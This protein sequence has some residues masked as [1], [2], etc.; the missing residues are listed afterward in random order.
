[1]KVGYLVETPVEHRLTGGSRSFLDLLEQLVP[2]GVEPFVAVHEPWAL[3]EELEKRGIPFI[4]T[5][6]YRPFVGT[7]EKARFYRI[8][9][10]VK[11]LINAVSRRRVRSF[12]RKSG[13]EL[14]HVN[15][16][17][18][19][20]VGAQ[21]ARDLKLPYVYHI[22]EYLSSDFGVEFYNKKQADRL[23]GG[24]S[25]VVA[26]SSSI[27][28]FVRKKYP[29]ARVER[30][31]NGLNAEKVGCP[32]TVRFREE[33]VKIVI[34]GRVADAKN[35]REA[36]LATEL[37]V[38]EFHENVLLYVVGY[39]GKDPYELELAQYVKEKGLSEAVRFVPFSDDPGS[40]THTCDIGL[41]CSVREAFGRVTIENM[42]ASLLVIGSN[43]GGTPE[44]IRDG[45]DG[46]LYELGNPREL[47][48]KIRWAIHHPDEANALLSAGKKKAEETF[49]IQH[50]AQQVF[51]LYQRL[52]E[53]KRI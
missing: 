32:D 16:Q 44:L 10:L 6:M 29:A 22:R 34:V 40:I 45:E 1:M 27:E 48:E 53:G 7:E 9:Y 8:K 52:S 3:T 49:S 46:F 42:M 15:S 50:T 36:I 41:T 38:K 12:F 11:T 26:I 14:I 43:T 37:L 23:I 25:A 4:T 18:C 51:A 20:V 33:P 39:L 24:A 28:E 21:V 13:V 47:A 19:G 30:I 35:Q 2:L 5:K 31:Y 17:F